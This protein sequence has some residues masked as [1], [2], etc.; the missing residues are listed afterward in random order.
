MNIDINEKIF[1][2]GSTGMVGSSIKRILLKRLL[3]KKNGSKILCPNRKE[4]DLS[5]YEKVNKWFKENKPSIVIIAAAKVGGILA[6]STM[7]YEFLLENIKIQN[8]IIENS[9]KYG[10][11]K[12]LFL[13]SSCIYPK[14]SQQPIKEEYLLDSKLEETNQWYA[15]AKITG[16]KLCESLAN[17]YSFDAISLMPSNLYGIGDNYNLSTSH[18][19]PAFINRFQNAKDNNL[20]EVTCWGT[21]N[22]LREFLYVDDLAEACIYS[23]EKWSTLNENAPLDKDNKKLYWLNVGSGEEISIRNLAEKIATVIGYMGEIKWDNTKP[24]GTPRKILDSSRL[25]NIGW[26]PKISLDEGLRITIAEYRKSYK[27]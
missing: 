12:V 19:L 25:N 11:K 24:D 17:Q 1:I 26:S 10:A 4:L 8:N 13:G 3:N 15:I 5:N 22:A 16:I 18:V 9:W 14:F 27:S 6:N 20:K 7:P 2:A 21:G 23:L